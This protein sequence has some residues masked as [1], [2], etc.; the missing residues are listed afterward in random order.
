M[1]SMN[2]VAKRA[3]VSIATVS[4]VLN[5]ST[6]V[7]EDTRDRIL[8]TIKELKYN[9]SR[10]AKRL[11]SKSGAGNMIGVMIPDIRNP[12]YVDVLRGVE[13]VIYE[14]GYVMIVCNFGQSEEREAGYIRILESEAIDGLIAAPVHEVNPRLE[15]M[16]ENGMPVV[17]ID[18]GLSKVDVDL[19]CVNNEESAYN[20][21]SYLIQRG[22][23]RI[24]HVGGLPTIPS[25]KAREVGYCRALIE[26]G[27]EVYE[28]LVVNGDSSYD[29]GVSI[30]EQ[31]LS[32]KEKP[33]A[34]FCAN[35][36]LTLGAL[37]VIN[38]RGLKVP[39]DIGIIGFDDMN[40]ACSLNPPLTAVHQPANEI[41]RRAGELL[42]QRIKDPS[43]E[44]TEIVLNTELRVR[45]SS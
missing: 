45:K 6:S 40:W 35:N 43:R 31:L 9:P 2:E 4:R 7:N 14:H 29:S 41:G 22:Y 34:L 23:K 24:G 25:S 37:E 33:D 44:T 15:K 11:R 13:S 20:A 10:V 28:N 17:C 8:K 30:T 12:F 27:L 3:G 38:R 42:I 19:V 21:V 16:I 18:R 5:N 26:S 1:A 39:E 36:L 32:Q